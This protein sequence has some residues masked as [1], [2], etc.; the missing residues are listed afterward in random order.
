MN[1]SGKFVIF[2]ANERMLVYSKALALADFLHLVV[3]LPGQ[4]WIS[5]WRMRAILLEYVVCKTSV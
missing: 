4:S 1:W 3:K 5:Y 2:A